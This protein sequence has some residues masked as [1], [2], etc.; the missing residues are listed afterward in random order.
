GSGEVGVSGEGIRSVLRLTGR[1][2]SDEGGILGDLA[3]LRSTARRAEILEELVV[4]RG[5]VLPLGRHVVLVE[6]RLDR[7]DR[8]ARPAVDTLVR[9]DV[10][11]PVTFVDAVDRALLDAGLVEQIDAGFGDDVSHGS[12]SF[13]PAQP[14]RSPAALT[15]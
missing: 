3:N 15:A 4:G 7:A 12:S 2:G 14:R 11:H 1:L 10:E 9:M 8:L 13:T 6:D 5:V